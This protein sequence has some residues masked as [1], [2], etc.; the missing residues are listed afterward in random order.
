[1]SDLRLAFRQLAKSPGFTF[2]A[3]ITL[4]LGLG[5]NAT[6]FAAV[7]DL[8][9]HPLTQQTR[10]KIV[11][12]YTARVGP[13]P[14][15]RPFAYSEFKL[16]QESK[17]IFRDLTAFNLRMA[18]IGQRGDYKRSFISFVPENY[19]ST[20]GIQPM[21]GR[22]FLPAETEPGAGIS[23]VVANH[24][25][26][27]RM[28]GRADFVGSQIQV[29]RRTFTVIGIA[30]AGFGGL[31]ASIG[32]DL[33]LP[34]GALEQLY[35]TNLLMP[36]DKSLYVFGN[37]Q[38]GVTLESAQQQSDVLATRLN[39]LRIEPEP[40]RLVLG[41]PSRFSLGSAAPVDESFLILFATLSMGLAIAVLLV[42]CLNLAN[43]LLARGSARKKEIA[44]RLSVGGSRGRIVRQLLTEG[45]VLSLLGAGVGLVVSVWAG[46]A[47]L[48][49]AQGT[50]DSGPFAMTIHPAI[51]SSLV[52]TSLVMSVIATIVFSLVPALR[53]TRIDLV[54]DLKQQPGISTSTERWSRFFSLGHSLLMAQL[55]LSLMLLF[56]AG[57][58]VRGSFAAT[59]RDPGFDR[60]GQV[61]A[62]VDYGFAELS[63]DEMIR[64]QSSLLER[65]GRFPQ[66][67]SAA[68][69]SGVPFNFELN[70]VKVFP[71]GTPVPKD[72]PNSGPRV[73]STTIS[74]GY[75]ATLGVP[76]LRGR[77]FSAAESTQ[78]GSRGVAIIDESLARKLFP[79]TDA[80]G[81]FIV[82][83]AAEAV[84][85]SEN[86]LEV[87]GI[88]RS[89]HDD[90]FEQAAPYRL[91][92]PFA[93]KPEANTYL[94]LRV[95]QPHAEA[96][97]IDHVRSQLQDLDPATPLLSVRRL[98]DYLQ[99]N[100]NLLLVQMAAFAFT[101]LGLVAVAL[102]LVGVYG[103]KAYAVAQRTRE[104]GIRLALGAQTADVVRLIVCQGAAQIAVAA[105]V[106]V[107]L[108]VIA[109]QALSKMLYRVEPFDPLLLIAA[110]T[111]IGTSALLACWLPARRAS[112][113]DPST[114]L[115]AE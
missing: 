61:V 60:E 37:L 49:W 78:P 74:H 92:R 2:V 39:S 99:K 51:D 9:L 72:S 94:H 24:T 35:G 54:T 68:L 29:N 81:R 42:A 31:H 41:P 86:A 88:V 14:D 26:W 10:Q 11:A 47:M 107:G 82:L 15:F 53:A 115:H 50:F 46:D 102:A 110:A 7:R 19:F 73:G 104:I 36:D 98:E 13:S 52:I 101:I 30:P 45:L 58:F 93:Q 3:V 56:C 113:V 27:Q 65:A 57:L 66:V 108:A 109:G 90:V 71:A 80:V 62:N 17:E 89:A 40:R 5:V 38:S 48:N 91:Y 1:M 106:G 59:E 112:R 76:V 25:F 105:A 20:F 8:V 75:F 87:V 83:N 84:G 43:M 32:P 67:T 79:D 23:V 22:F 70:S 85:N 55:A 28:G 34:F 21:A 16:L 18:A 97:V 100:I 114:A 111:T 77:D 4:A 44:I 63:R 33:W 95:T 12:V 69:A 6:V 64:R 103:L 96:A